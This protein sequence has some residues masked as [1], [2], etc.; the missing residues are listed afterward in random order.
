LGGQFELKGIQVMTRITIG[1]PSG[2]LLLKKKAGI[3][4]EG[5]PLLPGIYRIG[6]VVHLNME[7]DPSQQPVMMAFFDG[8]VFHV[9]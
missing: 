9:F 5:G 4:G 7:S 2:D 8:G 1:A 3:D 6:A